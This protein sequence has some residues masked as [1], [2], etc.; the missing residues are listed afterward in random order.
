MSCQM[1]LPADEPITERITHGQF[2][3]ECTKVIKALVADDD[4]C[5]DIGGHYGYFTFSL[6]GLARDG[7]VD[8]F[9]PVKAHVDRL[10]QGVQASG[11]NHVTIHHCAVADR[12][13]VMRLNFAES[14][15][16]DSMAYLQ[17]VGGVASEAADEHYASFSSTEV[18]VVTLDSMDLP[19]PDFIKI[20]AEG[21][22]G[23]ILAGGRELM[24]SHRPRM[25]VEVH[26]VRE[27]FQVTR[28]L[29]ECDYL[30]YAVT[31]QQTTMP[32]L[33]VHR[34]DTEAVQRVKETLKRDIE[35]LWA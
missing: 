6:A 2:E 18:N 7:R 33:L 16:D 5:I 3:P 21:A 32:L 34:Q 10:N 27:A 1:V 24:K 23:A 28:A 35:A 13:G 12:S 4:N 30:A 9:E 26:G 14:D 8:T 22:E 11:L 15:G 19:T 25:L 31:K 29:R 20:D 17:D